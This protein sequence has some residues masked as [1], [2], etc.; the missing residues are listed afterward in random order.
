MT[1]LEAFAV[2]IFVGVIL[3]VFF[4]ALSRAHDLDQEN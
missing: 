4:A 1:P 2:G 3:T